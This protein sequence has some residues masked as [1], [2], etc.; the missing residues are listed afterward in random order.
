MCS[1]MASHRWICKHAYRRCATG[2]IQCH[3]H[4]FSYTLNSKVRLMYMCTFMSCQK[5]LAV[6]N[7]GYH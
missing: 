7:A 5:V 4:L 2:V 6:W 3:V 1:R